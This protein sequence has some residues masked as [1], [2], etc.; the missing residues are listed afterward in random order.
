M[1]KS[2][3]ILFLPALYIL[4]FLTIACNSNKN[5]AERS[6][7]NSEFSI[8]D[9]GAV[10]DGTT[11][12]TK[13]IQAAIDACADAGG[14]MVVIPK[15]KFLSGTIILKS[16]VE[17]HL[18]RGTTLLGSIHQLDYPAQPVPE[19]RA[20]RDSAGFNAFIYAEG[21][22]DIAITGYGTIDGQGRQHK[23]LSEIPDGERDDRPRGIQFISCKN[24]TVRDVHMQNSSFWM[25]HYLNCED[26]FIDNIKVVNHSNNNNDGL[27]LDGCRRVLLSNCNIDSEDDGIV[28]KSTGKAMS[29]DIVITN[30]I[31]SSYTNAIKAGTETTGGFKNISISNCVIR[32]SRFTED[33]IYNGPVTG[34]TGIALM[35][36]DGGTLMG[37]NINNITIDGPPAPIYI[38]LG[39]RARKHIADA[40]EPPVGKIQN[41]SIS[42]V[43]SHSSR[44]WTSS[45]EGMKGH[46]IKDISFNNIQF[47]TIGGLSEG[48]YGINIKEDDKAYPE[49]DLPPMP[50]SGLYLRHVDGISID[51]MVI[52]SVKKDSRVPV[53]VEDVRNL[54]I[55][56][57]RLSGGIN[58]RIA[59]VKGKRL[60]NFIIDK[61]VG[62]K[63][64][65]KL[66]ELH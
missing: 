19:Y 66:V 65:G 60:T 28:L 18:L 3:T 26:V 37:V 2:Q 22:E 33:R 49:R 9:Y 48:D 7:H 1:K 39:N 47:F 61:P 38:R 64:K 27:N 36:V 43:V 34:L 31:I 13:A 25:Q 62:W 58:T 14:G 20:L 45:I 46:P 23:R 4:A 44:N 32:P 63:G 53:W 5:K 56:D 24:I 15:G 29:E 55:S 12:N 16:K 42:N 17:L 57:S 51:N 52:G 10:A 11:M 35:I 8:L 21:A 40:P 6:L 59:F 54:M 41:I 30:C 50:A